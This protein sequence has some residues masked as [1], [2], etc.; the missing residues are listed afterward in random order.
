MLSVLIPIYNYEVYDLVQDLAEQAKLLDVPVEI[1]CIDD[2]SERLY[3]QNNK[4]L[5]D[6]AVVSYSELSHNIGRAKIRNA[7][8]NAAQYEKLVFLDC[9]SGIIS[10]DFLATYL[11]QTSKVVV[12]GRVYPSAVSISA[13]QQLHWLYGTTRES[14]PLSERQSTPY[15]YFH[16]NN[17]MIERALF[18]ETL[19]DE[20]LSGYGYEDLVFGKQLQDKKVLITHIT[21]PVEHLH[22]ESNY[23][24]V[25]KTKH[26]V[27]NLKSLN[28]QGIYLGSKLEQAAAKVSRY[29]LAALYSTIYKL[30][31]TGINNNLLSEKPKLRYLDYYKLYHY[32]GG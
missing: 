29:R 31:S 23:D 3:K 16:S 12:G 27:Q 28:R 11:S 4:R 22:I 25:A 7:L 30:R 18:L 15:I 26:A 20:T 1:L 19:F 2:C 5:S 10:S 24:F 13:D 17:F 9:D 21:N 6:L 32:L 14:R 8:A